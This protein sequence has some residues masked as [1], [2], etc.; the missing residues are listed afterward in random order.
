MLAI[1]QKDYIS[2]PGPDKVW[3]VDGPDDICTVRLC[4]QTNAAQEG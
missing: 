3:P 1:L 2:I 4:S